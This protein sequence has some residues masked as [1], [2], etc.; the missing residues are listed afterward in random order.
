MSIRSN[1]FFKILIILFYLLYLSLGLIIS[2]DFGVTTDEEFQRYSGFYWLQYIL[3]FTPFENLKF[4]VEEKLL[5]IEGFTLPNPKDF[6]YYGVIFDLPLALF[7]SLLEIN[8]SQ[9]YFFLRH[10]INFLVFFISSIYVYKIFE[11]RFKE[12]GL[13]ILGVLLYITAPRIF[14]DSFFNN[15]DIVFLSLVTISIYYCF[16]LID[17][18]SYKNIFLFSLAAAIATSARIIGIFLPLSI[19]LIKLFGVLDRKVDVNFLFKVLILVLVYFLILIALWPYL[20]TDPFTNFFKAFSIFS[21]YIIDIKFLFNGDYIGS[22]NLPLLYIPTWIFISTPIF[23]ILFF[24]IGYI[25]CFKEIVS[26]ILKIENKKDN[27]IN[28]EEEKDFYIFFNFTSIITYLILFNTVLYNG[29]RQIYFLHFFIVYFAFFGIKYSLIYSKVFFNRKNIIIFTYFIII[30]F[31][32]F[33]LFKLHPFQSF[34]FNSIVSKK[35]VHN[36]YEV[37]YWGLSGRN[38]IEN[39]IKINNKNQN[40][41]IAVASWIPLERSISILSNED[42]KKIQ[43]LGQDYKNADFIFVNNISEVNKNYDDKYEVPNNFKKINE[44]I[45]QDILVYEIYKK[46]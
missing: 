22:K 17:N 15:K 24:L 11:N 21:N 44:L 28:K 41:K 3:N 1:N 32:I 4:I 29:W 19:I 31:S 12:N 43:I 33:N 26:N 27:W 39:L 25:I 10:K 30:S 9:S 2:K 46:D 23:T 37:D 42:K 38:F 16:K 34:Y 6:P 36:N 45:V 7:E 8:N 14:G 35:N 13:V 20:W 18:F 5:A 40:I